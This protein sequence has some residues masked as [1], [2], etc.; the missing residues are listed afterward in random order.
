MFSDGAP[1]GIVE[2]QSQHGPSVQVPGSGHCADT[3]VLFERG[4]QAGELAPW[5]GGCVRDDNG[6]PLDG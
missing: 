4:Q 2:H 6:R 1:F 3:A 5:R